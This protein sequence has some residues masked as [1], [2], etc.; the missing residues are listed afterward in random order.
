M[1]EYI[2]ERIHHRGG[3]SSERGKH[4]SAHALNYDSLTVCSRIWVEGRG[5]G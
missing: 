3:S 4:A 1:Q 5:C 2:F